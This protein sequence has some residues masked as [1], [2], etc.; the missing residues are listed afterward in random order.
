AVCKITPRT[1]AKTDTTYSAIEKASLYIVMRSGV[2]NSRSVVIE[3]D[4]PVQNVYEV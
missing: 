3:L 4:V 1:I 2:T